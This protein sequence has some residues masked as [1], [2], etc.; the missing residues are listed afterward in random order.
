VSEFFAAA[1]KP[2]VWKEE[3]EGIVR[4]PEDDHKAFAIYAEWLY[5][6]TFK[7]GFV[8]ADSGRIR[9]SL[10]Y[11]AA[12]EVEEILLAKAYAL[13]DK[14]QVPMF[15]TRAIDCLASRLEKSYGLP[16]ADLITF[17][18]GSTVTGSPLRRLICDLYVHEGSNNDEGFEDVQEHEFF[19]D[20]AKFSRA[21]LE[22]LQANDTL[23]IPYMTNACLY[24]D[25]D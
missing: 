18:Y 23:E 7:T 17:V 14:L 12:E 25:H 11:K 10:S 20:L 5:T 24:H 15:K 9:E 2:G 22:E 8:E 1:L 16:S 19:R 21:A 3:Q 13:G 4:M 6:G